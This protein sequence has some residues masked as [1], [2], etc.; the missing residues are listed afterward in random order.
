VLKLDGR[1]QS[2]L[3]DFS[4]D[5]VRDR[6]IEV[7]VQF[8]GDVRELQRAGLR[9]GSSIQGHAL[10]SIRLSALAAFASLDAVRSVRGTPR[11]SLALDK[12]VPSIN[13]PAVWTGNT[14]Y[15]GR[16]VIVGIVDSGIDIAHKNFRKAN[17][18][19]R[20]LRLWDQTK[21][22]PPPGTRPPSRF[23]LPGMNG[24]QL[25]DVNYGVEYTSTQLDAL[26][27]QTALPS[28]G[29]PPSALPGLDDL[30]AA[31]VN[32]T[33]KALVG[34]GT[35]VAGI[36]VGN[37][38]QPDGCHGADFYMGVA[39]EAD[40]I[41]VKCDSLVGLLHAFEYMI[42][43]AAVGSNFPDGQPRPIVINTSLGAPPVSH[44]ETVSL[45]AQVDHLL[46]GSSSRAIVA[47]AM[48]WAH[49]GAHARITLPAGQLS[50]T[51]L[52]FHVF[53]IAPDRERDTVDL[54]FEGS[55]A[56]EVALKAPGAAAAVVLDSPS[57][58]T[59]QK[60]I[61]GH[62]VDYGKGPGLMPP[63]TGA[64][65]FTIDPRASTK[66]I[67]R[68][69]WTIELR[70]PGGLPVSVEAWI[71]VEKED[72]FP[73]F[74]SSDPTNTVG[75]PARAS[76]VIA[77]G[78]YVG[79]VDDPDHGK[80]EK[81]SGQGRP[82]GQ[83]GV[84]TDTVKPDLVAPGTGI[85]APLSHSRSTDAC[86]EC[87]VDYYVVSTGTSMAAPHVAGVVALMFER[88]KTLKFFE[89]RTI[90]RQTTR[91]PPG[92]VLPDHVWGAGIV[93][94]QA[95]VTAVTPSAAPAIGLSLPPLVPDPPGTTSPQPVGKPL[96][97]IKPRPIRFGR[98]DEGPDGWLALLADRLHALNA[99]LPGSVVL[100]IATAL[101]STH[102]DEVRRLIDGNRRVATVWRR[103]GGPALVR[104][105][106]AVPVDVDASLPAIVDGHSVRTLLL[107]LTAIL[108]RYGSEALRADAAR[109]GEMLL[110]LPG[111]RVS[112][113]DRL[114]LEKAAL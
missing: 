87:C 107:R 79:R 52:P 70:E 98:V 67:R 113:L 60:T 61:D 92:L 42:H 41:V 63:G 37:G 47:A 44:K 49:S 46:A 109:H 111:T 45:N 91:K 13:V 88:N 27:F 85:F 76:N 35:H 68:G 20:I 75:S 51:P 72:M 64:F 110:A 101:V 3:R 5:P 104:H 2:A 106:I 83:A 36:A 40:M 39:P 1:L 38:Q 43:F 57:T 71:K 62:L 73:R 96:G 74:T 80:I 93:D 55:S 17:G 15:K 21:H 84:T 53:E 97:P 66:E 30:E 33:N 31:D 89:I 90:L 24:D 29:L 28:G 54:I 81:S 16:G 103:N 4:A 25:I 26:N 11:V 7:S 34:H 19:T 86:S 59:R 69:I 77:V 112:A 23:K 9:L 14:S 95:A 108:K 105:L 56:V 22:P 82:V 114:A 94:A 65:W 10:G 99:M 32:A 78:N 8:D 100:R 102:V 48:N 6:E 50:P 12:S 18:G 58:A